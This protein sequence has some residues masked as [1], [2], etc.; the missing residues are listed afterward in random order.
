MQMQMQRATEARL[1]LQVEQQLRATAAADEQAWLAS[2]AGQQVMYAAER[3]RQQNPLTASDQSLERFSS[4]ASPLLTRQLLRSS[5][6]RV[7]ERI[8]QPAA[9]KVHVN[10]RGSIDIVQDATSQ[11]LPPQP[12]WAPAEAASAAV[13]DAVRDRMGAAAA[14]MESATSALRAARAQKKVERLRSRSRSRSPQP[15]SA[16][17]R[18]AQ[19]LRSSSPRVVERIAKPA[20]AKVHVSR[21]G[22]VDIRQDATQGSLIPLEEVVLV[23]QQ[24]EA[25]SRAQVAAAKTKRAKAALQEAEMVQQEFVV[26]AVNGDGQYTVQA[27]SPTSRLAVMQEKL[28]AHKAMIREQRAAAELSAEFRQSGGSSRTS[29]PALREARG[30]GQAKVH[31]SRRGSIDIMQ[32][33]RQVRDVV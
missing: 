21:H 15:R 24:R 12:R 20:A 29:S 2:D 11:L 9:A 26:T 3:L 6:P 30:A 23:D 33:A 31:V 32:G 13:E 25:Y 18:T 14:E 5:S 17:P 27:T 10:R 7:V 16:S 1:D 8:A 22:S 28:A 4:G 19:F